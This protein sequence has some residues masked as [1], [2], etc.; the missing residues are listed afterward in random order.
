[1]NIIRIVMFPI[2]VPIFFFF[3]LMMPFMVTVDYV[4]NSL[5]GESWDRLYIQE[6]RKAFNMFRR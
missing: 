5:G 1:M 6:V 2:K 4:T 3:M